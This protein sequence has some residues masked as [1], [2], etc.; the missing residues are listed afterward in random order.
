M[1]AGVAIQPGLVRSMT[2]APWDS[3]IGLRRPKL[4]APA[5]MMVRFLPGSF[6]PSQLRAGSLSRMASGWMAME[7]PLRSEDA[8][9]RSSS[10]DVLRSNPKIMA[11]LVLLVEKRTVCGPLL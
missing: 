1:L 6:A 7:S 2:V 5:R 10:W 4:L 3:K 11:G 9:E 8:R